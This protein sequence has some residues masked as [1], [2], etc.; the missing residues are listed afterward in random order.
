MQGLYQSPEVSG[1]HIPRLMVRD[2]IGR[3]TALID[4]RPFASRN[5]LEVIS[6]TGF[7]CRLLRNASRR[8][9]GVRIEYAGEPGHSSRSLHPALVSHME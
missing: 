5:A 6:R 4:A 1:P 7:R 9:H 2:N 3:D 8:F